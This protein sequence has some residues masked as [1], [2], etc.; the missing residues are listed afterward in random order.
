MR[1]AALR[2]YSIDQSAAIVL[3]AAIINGS[4]KA[5]K[6][7]TLKG[8]LDAVAATCGKI[9]R[10]VK[11]IF[12]VWVGKFNISHFALRWLFIEHNE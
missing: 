3:L 8:L 11:A 12:F 4:I 9:G 6:L 5:V 10:I 1:I 2:C 7:Y